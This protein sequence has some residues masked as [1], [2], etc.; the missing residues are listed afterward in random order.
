MV[1]ARDEKTHQ[2]CSFWFCNEEKPYN[3]NIVLLR[4][5]SIETEIK[6][7]KIAANAEQGFFA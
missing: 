5:K 3:K 7:T 4:V 2:A 6:L 1:I